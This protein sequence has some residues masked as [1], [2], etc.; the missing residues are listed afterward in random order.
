[1]VEQAGNH[2][3]AP[4]GGIQSSPRIDRRRLLKGGLSAGPVLITLATRPVL[5]CTTDCKTPSA[6]ASIN[7]QASHRGTSSPPCQ[8]R[9]P[10][11]WKNCTHNQGQWPSPYRPHSVLDTRARVMQPA[12]LFHCATTGFNGT[13]FSGK[14]MLDV[15]C[16]GGGGT[17]AVGRH[18]TAALLNAAMTWTPVLGQTDVRDIWNEYVARGY[19]EPTAGVKWGAD[20]IVAYLQST[21]PL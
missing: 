4:D 3:A 21:M 14:T 10:G 6:F 19:Y 9:T 17:N 1:M 18:I 5:G 13:V 8:G 7:V 16:L 20:Q 12:T 11:F 2:E 15:L